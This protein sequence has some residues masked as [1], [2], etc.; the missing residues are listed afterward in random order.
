[1][2]DLMRIFIFIGIILLVSCAG[3]GIVTVYYIS[4]RKEDKADNTTQKKPE[5][6]YKLGISGYTPENFPNASN[7]QVKEYWSELNKFSEVYGVHIN[8]RDTKLL[9]NA[10]KEYEND[11]SVVYGYQDPKEWGNK[12]EEMLKVVRDYLQNTQKIKYV[13]IGNEINLLYEKNPQRFDKFIEDYKY[14]YTELKKDYQQ[15]YISTTFNYESLIGR[16]YLMGNISNRKDQIQLINQFKNYIDLIGLTSYPYFDYTNPVDLP[17]NYFSKIE[18]YEDI[19]IALTETG[20][21]SRES[22]GKKYQNVQ[23][24]G[25]TGSEMEQYE[26]FQKLQMIA[27]KNSF[28]F[29]SWLFLNDFTPYNDGEDGSSDLVLFDSVGLRKNN[30]DSKIVW[31]D[32]KKEF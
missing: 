7:N 17:E 28:E 10:I 3:I 32:W 26:Y 20:W 23:E 9:D 11:I 19:R 18:G 15:V 14:I 2:K 29:V 8:W 27:D 16:G 24:Q 1:M 5:R 22:Y 21:M 4:S 25:F 31:E 30:G 13:F 12:K 6:I